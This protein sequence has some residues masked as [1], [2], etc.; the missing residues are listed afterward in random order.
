[1]GCNCGGSKAATAEPRELNRDRV[2]RV[3][4]PRQVEV[5]SRRR[6]GGPG[7]ADY[8]WNGP[9]RPEREPS[10]TQPREP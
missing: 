4:Q 5:T 3:T 7:S 10:V 8:Y 2:A 9:P 6:G 1:M